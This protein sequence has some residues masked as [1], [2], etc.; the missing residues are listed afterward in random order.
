M[1]KV[2][3]YFSLPALIG[4]L[5]SPAALIVQ[6]FAFK[7]P[8]WVENVYIP[9]FYAPVSKGISSLFGLFPFS[10][11]EVIVVSAMLWIPL[12]LFFWYKKQIAA[13]KSRG[14]AFGCVLVNLAGLAGTLYFA[15]ILF[16]GL[17]YARMPLASS[18]GYEADG[19]T[20]TQLQSLCSILE[21]EAET[22]R[23]GL[24]EDDNGVF[25]P[26]GGLNTV[27]SRTQDSFNGTKKS[28]FWG[29]YSKPKKV[30]LSPLWAYTQTTGMFFPYTI[31]A[32]IN[33]VNTPMLYAATAA[34]EAAHQRGFMREDE[35]NFIAW[36][37][38]KDSTNPEDRYSGYMLAL[39]HAGNALYRADPQA[40][41][42]LCAE[43]SDGMKRDL[44]AHNELWDQ[45]EGKAAEISEQ[46]N[47][48]YLRANNQSDGVASYGRMVDLLFAHYQSAGCIQ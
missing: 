42:A 30:L 22:L 35:A 24:T 2:P 38:L 48:T 17:G 21:Q 11:A 19:M 37:V 28:L 3:Q 13:Q 14:G 7:H 33:T 18:L 31:E 23:E 29:N 40:Y 39:I 41:D 12:L 5:L 4:I 10:C 9:T 16:C 46:V 15:Y 36:Y 43:Y 20:R 34:H 32:N 45:Y 25:M 47:N 6:K 8:G 26:Q 1:K 44:N 27:L